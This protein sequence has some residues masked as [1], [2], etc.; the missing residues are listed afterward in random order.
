MV[1][2]FLSGLQMGAGLLFLAAAPPPMMCAMTKAPIVRVTPQTAEIQYDYTRSGA[3]LDAL[4]GRARAARPGGRDRM[5]GGLRIDEPTIETRVQWEYNQQMVNGQPTQ[6]CLWYAHISV[7]IMLKPVIYIA[8][9]QP[10]GPCGNAILGHERQHVEVDRKV[11]N[12]FAQQLG[13]ALK[14]HVDAT[15]AAGPFPATQRDI[16]GKKM[17]DHIA[18]II[19]AH[20]ELMMA[21]MERQQKRVDTEEEYARISAICHRAGTK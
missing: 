17:S 10:P 20:K 3:E 12:H 8:R 9:E 18:Q 13:A 4:A 19:A 14:A 7:D 6:V 11:I 2:G 5:T 1:A 21:E 16:W 15:G